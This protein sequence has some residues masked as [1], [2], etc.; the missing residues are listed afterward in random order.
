[1][2]ESGDIVP[3]VVGGRIGGGG[4]EGDRGIH[5]VNEVL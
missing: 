1:M 3:I 2:V 5:V 4:F